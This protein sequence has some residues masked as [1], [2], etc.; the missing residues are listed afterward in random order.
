[1][2]PSASPTPST[3]PLDDRHVD[4]GPG[5]LDVY[6]PSSRAASRPTRSRASSS[7]CGPSAGTARHGRKASI[8]EL[9]K[10]SPTSL[11]IAHRHVRSVRGLD[12]RATLMQDFRLACRCLEAHDFYEGVRAALIDRDRSPRWQPARLEDVSEAMLDSYFAP[13]GADDLSLASRAEMQ[14]VRP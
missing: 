1:M 10:H 9:S 12:L 3:R 6:A 11:K 8:A 13:L 4:P 2:P 7:D 5:E 14:A